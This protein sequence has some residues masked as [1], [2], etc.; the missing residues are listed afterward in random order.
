MIILGATGAGKDIPWPVPWVWRNFAVR[1]LR[2]PDLLVEIAVARRDGTYREYEAAE[3]GEA[4]H[5]E[6]WL[7]YP[8]KEAEAQG[9]TG[10]GGSS[11][12]GGVHHLQLPV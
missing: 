1:Y 12:Q 10:A 11:E 3:K 7:L 8:L 4:A 9:C 6:Q 5:S 2:L